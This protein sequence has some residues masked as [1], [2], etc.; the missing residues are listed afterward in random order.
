MSEPSKK[1]ISLRPDVGVPADKMIVCLTAG[2]L[3]ELIGGI[4]DQKLSHR[5][6]ED[7]LVDIDEAAKTLCISKEWL[8]HQHKK[9]PFTR[10]LG[11]GLLRFS[12]NAMQ[13]WLLEKV[14]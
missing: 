1:I 8:Y 10:K 7:R 6:G 12:V 5:M 14:S 11:R 4:I 3:R 13:K 2:E 9:L